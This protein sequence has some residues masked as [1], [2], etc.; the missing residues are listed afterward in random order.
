MAIDDK[1]PPA[2]LVGGPFTVRAVSCALPCIDISDSTNDMPH[3]H[4]G[5]A[6]STFTISNLLQPNVNKVN[7]HTLSY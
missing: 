1:I 3:R 7:F 4:V 5:K 2:G 6:L